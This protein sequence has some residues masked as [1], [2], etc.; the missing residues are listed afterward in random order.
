MNRKSK[1][2]NV[3]PV[4]MWAAVSEDVPP[5]IWEVGFYKDQLQSNLRKI[6]VIV[7]PVK[8]KAKP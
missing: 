7:S 2:K 4:K 5:A 1:L 8:P 6:R 3:K